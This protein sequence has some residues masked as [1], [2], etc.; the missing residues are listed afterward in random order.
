MAE[1][2]HVMSVTTLTPTTKIEENPVGFRS[3][4]LSWGIAVSP[5]DGS[6]Y[7]SDSAQ[8]RIRRIHDGVE[9]IFAGT[10]RE[11]FRDGDALTEAR[12]NTPEQICIGPSGEL[13]VAEYYNHRIRCIRDGVVSTVV[14]FNKKLFAGFADGGVDQAMIDSPRGVFA[15]T[16]TGVI[17]IADNKN[18]AIRRVQDG[19]VSTLA[20]KWLPR[21]ISAVEAAFSDPNHICGGKNGDLYMTDGAGWVWKI[22]GVS[23]IITL[24]AGNI[25]PPKDLGNSFTITFEYV[26]DPNRDHLDGNASEA[27]FS[28][29]CGIAFDPFDDAVYVSAFNNNRIRKI[30]DGVVTTVAG[31]GAPGK[32][33]GAALEATFNGPAGLAID[34]KAGKL[35][36]VDQRNSCVRILQ[37]R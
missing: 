9:T 13:Y 7:V 29:P 12:F 21:N 25:P 14:G 4:N 10:G 33:D 27:K 24:L 35:Y 15:D 5:R 34:S 8:H 19:S 18:R 26:V 22:A 31:T 28:F 1:P 36:I 37:L 20:G 30:K 3:A 32:A 23:G 16:S 2:S 11:G 17:Y 6:V